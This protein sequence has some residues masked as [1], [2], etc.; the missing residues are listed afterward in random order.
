M[1][2]DKFRAEKKTPFTGQVFGGKKNAILDDRSLL[3]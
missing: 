1:S 2:K 3:L